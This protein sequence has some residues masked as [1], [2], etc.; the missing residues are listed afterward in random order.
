MSDSFIMFKDFRV[1][2]SWEKQ[3]EGSRPV[4]ARGTHP[5]SRKKH[6]VIF[7]LLTF[8][9]TNPNSC[10]EHELNAQFFVKVI[11]FTVVGATIGADIQHSGIYCMKS[12]EHTRTPAFAS[13]A[14][15]LSR[16][17]IPHIIP[18]TLYLSCYTAFFPVGWLVVYFCRRH[19]DR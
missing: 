17:A 15:K 19:L 9:A 8:Q 13:T 2:L 6:I 16:L 10:D 1:P 5:F 3:N 7:T 4:H 18:K 14:H 12:T 11:T